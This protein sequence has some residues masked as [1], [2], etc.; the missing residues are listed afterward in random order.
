MRL[1]DLELTPAPSKRAGPSNY[2]WWNEEPRYQPL[3]NPGWVFLTKEGMADQIREDYP[4]GRRPIITGEPATIGEGTVIGGDGFGW[5]K[6]LVGWQRFPHI[7]GVWFGFNVEIG[8]NVTIDR[9]AL[10]DTEIG[11]G[12]K[13][14]NGV[15]IGHSAWVGKDTLITAHA[16]LGGSTT[17][18]FDCWIGLGAIIKEHVVIGDGAIIGMGAIVLEDV[19]AGE[20]WVGNPARKLR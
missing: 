3:G 9:G 13:I 6:G 1:N 14:D 20:T 10:A 2:C 8:S 12:V 18:G 15:H 16:I 5:L 7:G 11:T 4:D 19:P 17:I